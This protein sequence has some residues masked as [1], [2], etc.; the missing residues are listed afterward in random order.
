[1]EL[2]DIVDEN[3]TPTGKTVTREAAHRC[4]IRHRTSHVWILRK[5]NGQTQVLLQ[6]RSLDKDSYP[7]C[8]D[9]SSAGH[10]PSGQGFLESALR[11]LKEE[12]GV[13]AAE[14][15]L[16]YCGRRQFEYRKMFHGQE[17][18]DNQ[19]SNVYALWRD[20]EA[21]EF[22]VQKS[23]VDDVLWMDWDRC[24]DMVKNGKAPNCIRITELEM[25]SSAAVAG[26]AAD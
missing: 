16:I 10:I 14:E 21:G 9:I 1:M 7:G 12:L 3:G 8:Y 17:F 22:T 18:W 13:D 19:V 20:Q 2:L 24:I 6:K 26:T 5:H 15:E 23:E 11:E 25:I 4:G